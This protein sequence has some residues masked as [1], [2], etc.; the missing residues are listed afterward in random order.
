[1]GKNEVKKTK[2]TA[3]KILSVIIDIILVIY[4][5]FSIS[6][7]AI[8]ISSSKTDVPSI[9]G[10][11]LN[12]IQSGS[13]DPTFN[14][15]D[16][17]ICKTDV[18]CSALKEGDIIGFR[19][20]VEDA[21]GVTVKVVVVHRIIKIEDVNGDKYITTKGDN[22][23]AEDETPL[24][25]KDGKCEDIVCRWNKPGEQTGI[26]IEGG[27]KFVDFIKSPNGILYCL[28]I[29]LAIFFLY[30]LYSFIKALIEYK[31][32]KKGKTE[33]LSEEE[34][35]RIAEEYLAKQQ[36]SEDEKEDDKQSEE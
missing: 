22:N 5:I 33:E 2:S 19:T 17:L 6:V 16:L 3:R 11:T 31:Y 15:G 24:I 8:A 12:T 1:M 30:A 27:G 14:V 4:L 36:S 34:K 7:A 23:P 20:T 25:V 13:M 18:D 10:N 28:V 26:R 21:N 35:Q 9:F 29:P 32:E